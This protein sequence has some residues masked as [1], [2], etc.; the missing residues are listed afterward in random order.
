MFFFLIYTYEGYSNFIEMRI[1]L[2]NHFLIIVS[3]NLG[4]AAVFESCQF[5]VTNISFDIYF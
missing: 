5:Y 3:I 2:K 1:S 4:S